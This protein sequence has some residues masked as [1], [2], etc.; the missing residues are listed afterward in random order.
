MLMFTS[1]NG[2]DST[3]HSLINS[4][5][6]VPSASRLKFSSSAA[7]RLALAPLDSAMTVNSAFPSLSA[8]ATS[9]VIF[10]T[11]PVNIAA[12][13]NFVTGYELL[14]AGTDGTQLARQEYFAAPA[15]ALL[16]SN[17]DSTTSQTVA[18]TTTTAATTEVEAGL[19]GGNLRRLPNLTRALKQQQF[20]GGSVGESANID[21][22]TLAG[23]IEN[24]KTA[25]AQELTTLNETHEK[26]D[27]HLGEVDEYCR[28]LW[29][30]VRLISTLKASKL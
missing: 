13:G 18:P 26:F 16:E 8:L 12:G 3:A 29:Y 28:G 2:I 30:I 17:P 15:R 19:P 5:E 1:C 21:T 14:A 7:K 25:M 10:A 6:I 23:E 24:F 4:S 11:A 9:A 27:V 20:E 22:A